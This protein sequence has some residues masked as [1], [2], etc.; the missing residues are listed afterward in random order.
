MSKVVPIHG[1]FENAKAF[2]AHVAEQVDGSDSVMVF[3]FGPAPELMMSFGQINC[4]Q[5]HIALAG[6]ECLKLAAMDTED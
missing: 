5:S 2:L 6:A 3:S 4:R 1:H